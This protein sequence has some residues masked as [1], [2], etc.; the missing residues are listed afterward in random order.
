M[1]DGDHEGGDD[2][3]VGKEPERNE[4]VDS[5]VTLPGDEAD[6]A[7]ST[8]DCRSNVNGEPWNGEE[9]RMYRA[10]R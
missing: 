5:A 1:E 3:A 8:D 4:G 6:A 7:E 2:R 10:W 9:G